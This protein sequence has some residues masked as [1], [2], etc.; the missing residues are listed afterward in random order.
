MNR[1]KIGRIYFHVHTSV[2]DSNKQTSTKVPAFP[3]FTETSLL[4]A[5]LKVCRIQ[6]AWLHTQSCYNNE[7]TP[8]FATKRC[9]THKRTLNVEMIEQTDKTMPAVKRRIRLEFAAVWAE[10][11][12][13]T[14]VLSVKL[15]KRKKLHEKRLNLATALP[16]VNINLA[17]L[18]PL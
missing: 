1:R 18:F 16:T 3:S 5:V 2:Y 11:D 6:Y 13:L 17:H 15:Y 14:R 10:M 7:G 12:S 8:T 4:K 9:Q